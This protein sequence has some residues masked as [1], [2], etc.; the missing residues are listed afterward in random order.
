MTHTQDATQKPLIDID[1][2]SVALDQFATDRDWHQFHSPKNLVMALTGEV[3]E[4]TEIFQWM[5]EDQSRLAASD[6]KTAQPIKDELADVMLYLIRLSSVLEVDLNE[7]V[8]QKLQRNAEKYPADKV[9]GS[10]QK[11]DAN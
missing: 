2:L 9:R 1:R 3:G 8:T 4:L 7:A 11:Y 6:A 5:T 10:S